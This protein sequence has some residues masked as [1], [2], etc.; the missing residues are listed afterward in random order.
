MRTE[1][2]NKWVKNEMQRIFGAVVR[3]IIDIGRVERGEVEHVQIQSKPRNKEI[4]LYEGNGDEFTEIE[5]DEDVRNILGRAV[6]AVC[7]RIREGDGR[8]VLPINY[9]ARLTFNFE[10]N[11]A[12]FNM[13][14]NY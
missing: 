9:V 7:E 8:D 4:S 3:D 5:L 11:S 6:C 13:W 12:E 14:V 10:T 1:N 2:L